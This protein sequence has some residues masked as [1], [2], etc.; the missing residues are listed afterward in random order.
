MRLK[1]LKAYLIM[2]GR[3]GRKVSWKSIRKK[4]KALGL[5]KND[6][7]LFLRQKN[8]YSTKMNEWSLCEVNKTKMNQAIVE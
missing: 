4:I 1:H 6:I 7:F 8:S 2:E 3:L 5:C